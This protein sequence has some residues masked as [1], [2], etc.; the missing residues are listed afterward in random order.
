MQRWGVP[1]SHHV[2]TQIAAVADSVRVIEP[3]ACRHIQIVQKAPLA[4]RDVDDECRCIAELSVRGA[5]ILRHVHEQVFVNPAA[6]CH[7]HLAG[8]HVE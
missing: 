8:T 1:R 5:Q 4:Q 6:A 7:D 2:L 3:A